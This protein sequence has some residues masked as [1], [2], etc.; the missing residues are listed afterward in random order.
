MSCSYPPEPGPNSH[1]CAIT[2]P[3]GETAF[4]DNDST[5]SGLG[6]AYISVADRTALVNVSCYFSNLLHHHSNAYLFMY[7]LFC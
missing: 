6:S 1:M 7:M 5:G 3:G 2:Y 4:S